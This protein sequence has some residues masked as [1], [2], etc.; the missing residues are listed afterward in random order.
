MLMKFVAANK[1]IFLKKAKDVYNN[2]KEFII[3]CI[4][5][6]NCPNVF[7]EMQN[8][9]MILTNTKFFQWWNNRKRYAE[10]FNKDKIKKINA[11]TTEVKKKS[12]QSFEQQVDT[13]KEVLLNA[14]TKI[15][16]PLAEELK[17]VNEQIANCANIEEKEAL[18]KKANHINFLI[19]QEYIAEKI[20]NYGQ[21]VSYSILKNFH[22]IEKVKKIELQELKG[23][24]ESLNKLKKDMQN[25][26]NLDGDRIMALCKTADFL[27][28]INCQ[29]LKIL[30]Y[31]SKT[32]SAPIEKIKNLISTVALMNASNR[33]I[34]EVNL[35]SGQNELLNDSQ[36]LDTLIEN[37][38]N[39]ISINN[40]N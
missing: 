25:I 33:E 3:E 14:D 40:V 24:K 17:E 7:E 9:N 32:R 6:H 29:E 11:L 39:K 21:D 30:E 16:K 18:K 27:L 13:A 15:R 36:K 26:T 22:D 8:P 19:K 23:I 10:T 35:K 37:V 5:K 34:Q 20:K 2:H 38:K 31:E 12:K 4:E 1:K 28:K